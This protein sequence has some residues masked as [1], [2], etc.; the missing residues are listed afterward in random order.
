[1]L[2]W[3]V[4]RFSGLTPELYARKYACSLPRAPFPSRRGWSALAGERS[5]WWCS[6]WRGR[7]DIQASKDRYGAPI[8]SSMCAEKYIVQ[9][10][11]ILAS[12]R[13]KSSLRAAWPLR[14]PSQPGILGFSLGISNLPSEA[15]STQLEA[16]P[17]TK[18]A[19]EED[20][21]NVTRTGP[22]ECS[23]ALSKPPGKTSPVRRALK[24]APSDPHRAAS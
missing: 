17:G 8:A 18:A 12:S 14:W 15:F 11:S 10:G 6:Y 23:I 9:N 13:F 2:N 22:P 7:P 16:L 1:M 24:R 5:P 3:L 4:A 21:S 19:V 20:G